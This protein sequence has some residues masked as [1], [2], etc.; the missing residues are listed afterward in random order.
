MGY[1]YN[2]L[3]SIAVGLQFQVPI[4]DIITAIEEYK[5]IG[6]RCEFIELE[7]NILL[8]DDSYNS[9]FESLESGLRMINFFEQEKIVILGDILELGAFSK[10]IHK[11]IK[12]IIENYETTI[13]VGEE[14]KNACRNNFIW[15]KNVDDAMNYLDTLDLKNKLIYVKGSHATQ[16]ERLTAKIKKV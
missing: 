15:C 6:Q 10:K 9:S 5:T 4:N 13:L 2:I 1:I 8:I 11:K 14:M 7:D 16:L 3:F 12:K